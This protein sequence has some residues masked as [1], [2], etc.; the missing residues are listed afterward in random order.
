MRPCGLYVVIKRPINALGRFIGRWA[1]RLYLGLG[2][3]LVA[4]VVLFTLFPQLT[5][6]FHTALFVL[7]VLPSPVKPQPWF[8]SAPVREE[9]T[10]DRPDGEGSADIYY[11]PDGRRR[12]GLL[13]FLGANAAG[14]DDPDVVNF[15]NALSRA[16]FAAMFSW[17]PTMGQRNNVDPAEI[18]NQV[19]AFRHLLSRDYVDPE[20]VGMA[21]FSV[22][23]SFIMVA[24]ANPRI[25]D[26]VAFVNSFGAYYDAREFFIQIASNTKFSS[27]PGDGKTEPWAVDTLT[28]RIFVNEIIQVVD[29]PAEREL[30]TRRFVEGAAG[31]AEVSD[32]DLAGLSEGADIS[33]RLLEGTTPENAAALF[34]RMPADFRRGLED[35]SP[36]VHLPNLRARL[37]IMHDVGDRLIPVGESRRLVAALKESGRADLRYTE[38]AIFDHV[39]PGG[40]RNLWELVKGAGKLYRHTYGIIAI[41]N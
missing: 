27:G 35:I 15:G 19:W 20:R 31:D 28:R 21:G 34:D 6:G 37:L 4:V 33:R 2:A 18:E 1:Y 11:I 30:L 22:G 12:A 10:Y 16:G 8:T 14:R 23:G 7:Q 13:V 9:I 39:R 24:A 17:S 32:A 5:T 41:R 40:D 3:L 29:D 36:S 25:R 26:D 38:T